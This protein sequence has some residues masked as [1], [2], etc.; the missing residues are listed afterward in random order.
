[1]NGHGKAL[2]TSQAH[3]IAA[4]LDAAMESHASWVDSVIRVLLFADAPFP[5][6]LDAGDCRFG[7][8]YHDVDYPELTSKPLFGEIGQIHR[9]LHAAAREALARRR[10]GE[11]VDRMAAEAFLA[12]ASELRRAV[13]ELRNAFRSDIT[14]VA[15]LL[16]KVFE[17]ASEGVIVTDPEARILLVNGAF[18][19]TTGYLP[20]DAVG[21]KPN[22]LYSGRHDEGFYREMW[23]RLSENG[24]W[25][26]EI[27]NR[28]KDG[29]IYLEWLSVSAVHDD[30]GRLVN[31][32]ALFSDITRERENEEQLYRLAHYDTL[33]GLPN[34]RL[35]SDLLRQALSHARRRDEVVGVMFLDLD[36]FKAI[37]DELGHD[38]GDL[39]LKQVAE[40]LSNCLRGSDGIGRYGGDEFTIVARDAQAETIEHLANKILQL[41]AS[42]YTL[43]GQERRITVSVGIALYPDHGRNGEIL[44]KRADIAMYHAKA[45]G[46]N[47]Y[48]LFSPAMNG[49]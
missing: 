27:W 25:E 41:V 8:W 46:K 11:S 5:E 42:P 30:L 23:R 38:A 35:F 40:R 37:N 14:L 33:T 10:E 22:L 18:T 15:S 21:K 32:V 20:E 4:E 39:L 17:N 47:R 6:D 16:M 45:D 9:D 24:F 2:I 12:R 44:I 49:S 3:R 26:G 19:E 31:Y 28:R 34:R 13:S 48:R 29:T 1:M 7:R 36:G 43:N